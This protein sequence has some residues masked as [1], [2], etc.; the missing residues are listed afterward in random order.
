MVYAP[1]DQAEAR[2]YGV[3]RYGMEVQRLC[4]VLERRLAGHGDSRGGAGARAEGPRTF[5][6]GERYTVADMACFP[7]FAVLRG[8]GY[9]R[10]G[11][12]R[13]RDFL[14][15]QR[16]QHLSA[17]ADRIEARIQVRRGMRVCAGSPKPWLDPGHPLHAEGGA[18]SKL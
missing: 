17:W 15:I 10:E 16:Y 12:P 3:A 7:W 6:V 18:A 8:K 11:Q 5:L 4:D 2:D 13:T 9:D 1:A 14:G